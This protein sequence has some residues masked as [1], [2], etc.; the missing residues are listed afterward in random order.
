MLKRSW[1]LNMVP[2][3][4]WKRCINCVEQKVHLTKVKVTRMEEQLQKY[5]SETQELRT[6]LNNLGNNTS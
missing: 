5:L 3:G 1:K 6:K 2:F 4:S